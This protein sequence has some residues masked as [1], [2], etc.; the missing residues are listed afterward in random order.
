M[1][2]DASL[3]FRRRSGSATDSLSDL[4]AYVRGYAVQYLSDNGI[5][6][7][8][9]APEH[10]PSLFVSGE[11][12]RNIYLTVKE[13]LHNVVK[14]AQARNVHLVIGVVGALTVCIQDDGRGFDEKTI[15]RF[16]NGLDNMQK[17]I[18]S[19]GGELQV[20]NNSGTTITFS[21]PLP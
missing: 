18:R 14:H 13:A 19:I 9:D 10:F 11:F 7:R 2:R 21:V 4:L 5:Q 12:R 3:A 8:V 16:S 15:R 1:S 20:K 17:R 6:C